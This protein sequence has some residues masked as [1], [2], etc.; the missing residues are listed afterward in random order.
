MLRCWFRTHRLPDSVP[1]RSLL[2]DSCSQAYVT[3]PG[4]PKPFDYRVANLMA[5]LSID[6]TPVYYFRLP[7]VSYW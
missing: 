5:D 3:R 4:L 2:R 1:C 7:R 6:S